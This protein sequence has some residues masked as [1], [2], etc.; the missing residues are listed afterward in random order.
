MATGTVRLADGRTLAYEDAGDP[1]GYPVVLAHG[2]PGS[3]LEA[4]VVG[5]SAAAAGVRLIC[6]DRPG[7]GRSDPQPGR[8]LGDWP[9]DVAALADQLALAQFAVVGFSAG[10]PYAL[11]CAALLPERVSACGLASSPGPLDRPG[12]TAGMTTINRVL[13][14]AGR[15]APVVA[16][17]LLRLIERSARAEPATV[18]RRMGQGMAAA[19]RRTLTTPTIGEPF[20][21]AVSEAF[22]QGSAGPILEAALL[23]RPWP[24]VVDQISAPTIVWHGTDDRNVPAMWATELGSRIPRAEVHRVDGAGHLLFLERAESILG[25]VRAIASA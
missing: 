2:F 7:F 1:G 4:R 8:Q 13:F 20:G 22:R 10:G 18:A 9:T 3:R 11:A 16:G 21:A 6:P 17:L 12:S 23:V 5:A 19:D 24:F 25:T 14:G 15:R